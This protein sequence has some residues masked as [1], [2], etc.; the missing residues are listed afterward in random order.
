[1]QKE[2]A[3]IAIRKPNVSEESQ[4]HQPPQEFSCKAH[5]LPKNKEKILK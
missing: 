1:M 5:Q 2:I 4:F 3:K